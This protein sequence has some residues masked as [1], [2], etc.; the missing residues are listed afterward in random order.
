[1]KDRTRVA[2]QRGE[3]TKFLTKAKNYMGLTWEKMANF[4]GVSRSMIFVYLSEKNTLPRSIVEKIGCATPKLAKPVGG[5][6]FEL[7]FSRGRKYIPKLPALCDERLAEFT[8]ILLGD[9]HLGP[10]NHEISVTGD[11]QT[12]GWYVSKYVSS[13]VE[14]LFGIKPLIYEQKS[15]SAIRCRFYS[16][17]VFKFLINMGASRRVGKGT[18]KT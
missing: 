13:L 8:G 10:T 4:C 12:D 15:T 1:M 18:M 11:R 17:Q 3:Q 6:Y 14:S 7:S 5:Q 9:G 16:H 2:F